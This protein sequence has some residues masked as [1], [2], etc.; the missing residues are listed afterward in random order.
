MPGGLVS[1]CMAR[2]VAEMVPLVRKAGA[3]LACWRFSAIYILQKYLK[4][5]ELSNSCISF[6]LLLTAVAER[7]FYGPNRRLL[8][9]KVVQG[10]CN[11]ACLKL[12][13]RRL[14]YAKVVQGECN[15]ACLELPNRR[16]SYAKVV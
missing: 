4:Y 14:S 2:G 7:L 10:E 1:L 3:V 6:Y 8:Y 12:P 16:L 13:N 5:I 9:A 11:Q 15:Q